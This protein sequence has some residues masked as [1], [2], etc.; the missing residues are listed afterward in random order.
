MLFRLVFRGSP[1]FAFYQK[2][3]LASHLIVAVLT[4]L[5]LVIKRLLGLGFAGKI[6][7]SAL[8]AAADTA[9]LFYAAQIPRTR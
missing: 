8:A 9:P 6:F 4:A 1:I 5:E 3:R 7:L 2:W